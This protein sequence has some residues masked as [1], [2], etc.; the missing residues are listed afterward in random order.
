M[1]LVFCLKNRKFEVIIDLWYNN[2]MDKCILKN[3]HFN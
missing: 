3:F 2:N 1:Y